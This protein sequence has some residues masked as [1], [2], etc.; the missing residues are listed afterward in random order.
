MLRQSARGSTAGG[1]RSFG[2]AVG[3]ALWQGPSSLRALY[4]LL[5]EPM[6]EDLPEGYPCELVLVLEGDLYLVGVFYLQIKGQLIRFSICFNREFRVILFIHIFFLIKGC[7]RFPS[8]A[9]LYCWCNIIQTC[10]T[11]DKNY[12]YLVVS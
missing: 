4:K 7:L 3:R 8:N 2:G 10:P 11:Q 5:L 1:K 6:E 12:R 9:G